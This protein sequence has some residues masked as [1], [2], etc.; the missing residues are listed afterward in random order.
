MN[1]DQPHAFIGPVMSYY[2]RITVGFKRLTDEE[3]Q[4]EYATT[5]S[6]RP[7]LVNLYLANQEGEAKGE[8]ISLFTRTGTPSVEVQPRGKLLLPLRTNQA[9]GTLSKLSQ[10]IQP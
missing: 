6:Y 9:D 4:T 5:P 2:E 3:W 8:S 10:P 1:P 7:P